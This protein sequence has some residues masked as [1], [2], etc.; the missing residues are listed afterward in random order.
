M[1]PLRIAIA[2]I[3]LVAILASGFLYI[4]REPV[5]LSI[6]N[7]LIVQDELHPADVIHVISGENY[8]AAYGIQL[9]N[10]GLGKVLFFTGGWCPYHNINHA[11][12]SRE[13]ALAQGASVDA[14]VTDEAEIDST[15]AEATRLKE[16]I[17]R[18]STPVN[19]IIVV[20]D[21]HHMR[22]A[23][24]TY[25]RIFGDKVKIIMA[26]VPFEMSMYQ[27]QWWTDAESRSM[28]RE[29]YLKFAF[30]IARYQLSWGKLRDWLATFDK[31]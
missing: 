12:Y 23:R 14:I 20:S 17:D 16:W 24:W 9:Y 11:Q 1:H 5:L 25:R 18:N 31:Y 2:S 19:S 21:P 13:L 28:I 6:G 4:F 7:F 8:R 26:P 15:Y 27:R 29:E 30:Y 22:R 10:Q 3:A